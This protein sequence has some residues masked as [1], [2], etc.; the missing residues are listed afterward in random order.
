MKRRILVQKLQQCPYVNERREVAC[1]NRPSDRLSSTLFTLLQRERQQA[2]YIFCCWSRVP[3]GSVIYLQV[4]LI[5][6]FNTTFVPS[7]KLIGWFNQSNDFNSFCRGTTNV[8]FP[9]IS[10]LQHHADVS[11]LSSNS[12]S[13][14]RLVKS[15]YRIKIQFERNREHSL[16]PFKRLGK[17]IMAVGRGNNN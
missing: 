4:T 1:V 16:L 5:D 13:L 7:Q 2:G 9:A 3:F 14:W 15:T 6:W 10:R 8:L 17:F 12:S 11:C